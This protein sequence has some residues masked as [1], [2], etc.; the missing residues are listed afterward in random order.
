[1]P[2][3]P[4]VALKMLKGLI[5]KLESGN[6]KTLLG[7][8]HYSLGLAYQ[9]LGNFPISLEHFEKAGSIF[10]GINQYPDYFSTRTRM[11]RIFSNL[12]DNSKA[13]A[14]QFEAKRIAEEKEIVSSE[15]QALNG[16]SV[17]FTRMKDGEKA[18]EHA[19]TAAKKSKEN[20][21]IMLLGVS[22]I[23]LGNSSGL[24]KKWE[25]ALSYWNKSLD[26]FLESGDIT[27]Q[28]SCYGNLGIGYFHLGETQKGLELLEKCLEIKEKIGEKFDIAKTLQYLGNG[29][30]DLKNYELA[31]DFYKRSI[32]ISESINAH[33]ISHLVYRDMAKNKYALGAYK[34]AYDF[35]HKFFELKEKIFSEEMQAQVRN[36]Q[37]RSEIE[38]SEREKEIFRLKNIDLEEA[39]KEI[40]RQSKLLE[41]K[42][43][44]ITDSITFAST[45]QRG[46]L[47][48]PEEIT[49]LNPGISV[50]FQP[51]DVLSGDFFWYHNAS[52]IEILAVADCTG[53]G[54]PGALL[55]ILGINFLNQAVKEK[56]LLRPAAILSFLNRGLQNSFKNLK[57]PAGHGMDISIISYS[58]KDRSLKFAGANNP[59]LL[60]LDGQPAELQAAKG[61]IGNFAED[62]RFEETSIKLE[63]G[64]ALFLFSDGFQDQ[65][66][67]TSGR[68]Y[69]K[70]N[71]KSLLAGI[72]DKTPAIQKDILEKTFYSWKGKAEQ[73]DDVLVV[74]F[75]M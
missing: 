12:G 55:S 20:N 65:F 18:L 74:G 2:E 66:G 51:R 16:L 54:V 26:I 43:K 8:C 5:S 4:E 11:A 59:A 75:K 15:V 60:F 1:L 70:R 14:I 34:E 41:E 44:D 28:G 37:V 3:K 71:F 57:S 47:Q 6:N 9:A 10:L 21:L 35:F 72:Y 56:N 30:H 68:R 13:L 58:A 33:S 19:E 38:N 46:V 52:G 42:N 49:K 23:N 40:T 50:F 67:E 45:I 61:T 73:T 31:E 63:K 17:I 22:Y 48:D 27:Y 69:M 53:H 32:E 25:D 64:D 36:L 62:F 24:L 7:K 39:N 29:N